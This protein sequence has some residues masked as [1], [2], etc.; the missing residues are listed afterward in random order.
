MLNK[1]HL[2]CVQLVEKYDLAFLTA[3]ALFQSG[4]IN[5][6]IGVLEKNLMN[7]MENE[8]HMLNHSAG[9]IGNS[10]L[11]EDSRQGDNDSLEEVGYYKGLRFLL[12]ARAYESQENKLYAV[13]FYKEALRYNAASFEAFN[14]LVANHLL[15]REEKKALFEEGGALQK[16]LE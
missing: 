8:I 16:A 5:A 2:R 10:S 1:E 7:P 11:C 4:N 13:Q 6:C 3:Q 9:G 12:L 15:T 14:R